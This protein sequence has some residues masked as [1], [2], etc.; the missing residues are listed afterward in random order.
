MSWNVTAIH[1]SH[2]ILR[3]GGDNFG[4]ETVASDHPRA[5]M[6]VATLALYM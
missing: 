6:A 5:T 3:L 2:P 1:R 4:D